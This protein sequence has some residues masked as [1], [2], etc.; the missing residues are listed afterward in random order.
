MSTQ[1]ATRTG[2]VRITRTIAA[3]VEDVWRAW[4]EEAAFKKW[5][6]PKDY[7]CPDAKLDVR[8]G[9][10]SLMSMQ[11]KDGKKV[12][13][14]AAY[15]EVVPRRRLVYTDAFSDA[16]GKAITPAE[17]GMSGDWPDE[18][19]ATVTFDETNGATV[20]ILTHSGFPQEA[21]DECTQGWN[22]SF[23]KLEADLEKD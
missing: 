11:G 3:P 1:A 13:S 2:T 6:G 19:I 17:A 15:T 20:M 18:L 22:E 21:I 23:D 9:G 8:V 5:W 4:T 10:M 12:W 14:T 7:T 16:N